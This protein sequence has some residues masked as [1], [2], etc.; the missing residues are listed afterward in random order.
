MIVRLATAADD[1]E[2]TNLMES[3]PMLGAIRLASACRPS[4]FQALRVEGSDPIVCVAEQHGEIVGVGAATFRNVHYNGRVATLRYLSA[5]RVA[6]RAR[7]SSAM[8]RGFARLREELL[9]R[10]A[11]ITLTSILNDNH[12]ALRVLTKKRATLPPYERLC[13]CIT[14]VLPASRWKS[15]G[16]STVETGADACEIVEFF[17]THAASRNLFPVCQAADLDGTTGS[18]FPNLS[19]GDFLVARERGSIVGVMGCWNVMPLRQ[20]LVTGYAFGLRLARPWLN[21][22]AC[23]TGQPRLPTPGT[24]LQLAFGSLILVRND[25]PGVFRSLVHAALEW[26]RRQGLDYFVIAMPDHDPLNAG[27]DGVHHRKI[28]S[29][30]FRVHFENPGLRSEPG[31]RKLHLEGAML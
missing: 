2:I 26:T 1:V 31:G 30:I 12:G 24:P 5:M 13:N 20:S 7:G 23:L 6:D 16:A 18:S 25:D 9:T 27:F 3:V 29:R 15:P 21:L 11:D 4:F 17:E 14:R 10:P 8:A 19:S 22:G 28:H